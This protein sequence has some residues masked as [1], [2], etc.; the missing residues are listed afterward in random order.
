[1]A[2]RDAVI[3]DAEG[4]AQVRVM[5]WRS[6]YKGIVPAETLAGMSVEEDTQRWEQRF[7]SPIDATW[8]AFVAVDETGRI[9]GF[10]TGGGGRSGDPHYDAEVYAL[11]ILP[12]EQGRGIGKSLLEA[13]ARRQWI[14]PQDD[15]PV[16][17]ATAG[18]S[19]ELGLLLDRFAD[20]LSCR[21]PI[22]IGH[23]D[24]HQDHIRTTLAGQV[25]ALAAGAGN[26][27]DLHIPF[28]LQQ[29]PDIF[30]R[31]GDI[32]YDDDANFIVGHSISPTIYK[33]L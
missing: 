23:I 21:D 16:L 13:A 2:I 22:H 9:V 6:A 31:L 33:Y 25:T 12:Q 14:Q 11:Y 4:M 10:C 24:V 1:M 29:L 20:R 27:D 5:T 8:F 28:K 3:T 32:V 17:T 15:V 30:T 26:A 18:L 7:S 19:D